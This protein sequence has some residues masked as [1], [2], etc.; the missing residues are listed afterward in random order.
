MNGFY[1]RKDR[2]IIR[3]MG[4]AVRRFVVVVVSSP[5][6]LL[7][8]LQMTATTTTTTTSYSIVRVV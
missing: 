7:Q 4:N 6:L 3:D 5:F 2:Y 8:L 1:A